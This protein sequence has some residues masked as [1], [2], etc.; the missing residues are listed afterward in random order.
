V[1]TSIAVTPVNTL[2][3]ANIL[4]PPTM[5]VDH[6]EEMALASRSLTHHAARFDRGGL[7]KPP[8]HQRRKPAGIGFP[9]PPEYTVKNPIP[10][11][12]A[13]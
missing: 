12:L 9:G 13:T 6:R 7:T 11:R 3:S 10:G 2:F 1:R 4:T 8:K 5:A